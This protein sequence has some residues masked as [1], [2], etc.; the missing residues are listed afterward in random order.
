MA[1]RA[2]RMGDLLDQVKAGRTEILEDDNRPIGIVIPFPSDPDR[3]VREAAALLRADVINVPTAVRLAGCTSAAAFIERASALGEAVGP[4]DT[5]PEDLIVSP[6]TPRPSRLSPRLAHP[7]QARDFEM[8]V[9]PA[10][11]PDDAV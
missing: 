5:V 1:A 6:A 10:E 2:V 7:A 3:R 9:S 8:E 11:E 4:T